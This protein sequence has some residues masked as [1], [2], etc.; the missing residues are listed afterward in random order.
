MRGWVCYVCFLPLTA[1][2][3]CMLLQAFSSGSSFLVPGAVRSAQSSNLLLPVLDVGEP[4]SAADE[5]QQQQHQQHAPP[6]YVSQPLPA[7]CAG[8][9]A[10]FSF[11]RRSRNPGATRPS[12]EVQ[13]CTAREDSGTHHSQS[14]SSGKLHTLF[15]SLRQGSFTMRDISFSSSRGTSWSARQNSQ[16][17]SMGDHPWFV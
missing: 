17:G 11:Y 12:V 14:T 1:V 3:S 4:A 13:S 15:Q 10:S 5:A 7:A 16:T 8:P 9:G 2:M 6:G